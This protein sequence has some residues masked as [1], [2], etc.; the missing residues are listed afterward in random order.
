[1]AIGPGD[2]GHKLSTIYYKNN[3]TFGENSYCINFSFAD[4]FSLISFKN[5]FSF[6]AMFYEKKVIQRK[7]FL[8]S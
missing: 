1:M 2:V 4:I 7:W 5:N 3:L 6:E 8:K